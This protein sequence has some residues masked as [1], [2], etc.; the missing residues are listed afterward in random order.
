MAQMAGQQIQP[1][2]PSVEIDPDFDVHPIEFEIVRKW[3]N[4]EAGRQAK[5]DNP[6]GYKNVLLH[7]KLHLMEIQKAM[8]Q[9]QMQAQ[10]GEEDKSGNVPNAKRDKTKDEA[11]V[12]DNNVP[13]AV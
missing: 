8:M 6:D 3:A 7:G 2:L 5:I 10:A 4:G 12:G 11:P 13:A 9:Q 1:E